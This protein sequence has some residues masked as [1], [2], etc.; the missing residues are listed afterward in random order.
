M[1]SA[2][3]PSLELS[4]F[5]RFMLFKIDINVDIRGKEL[6]NKSELEKK[7]LSDLIVNHPEAAKRLN[8]GK[9]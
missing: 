5:P 2:P 9:L 8:P 7:A 6:N 1:A 3:P 4:F